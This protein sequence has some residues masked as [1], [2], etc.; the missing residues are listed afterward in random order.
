MS[1]AG[2]ETP[3]RCSP[4]EKVKNNSNVTSSPDQT[5]SLLQPPSVTIRRGHTSTGQHLPPF[6]A[7]ILAPHPGFD[8]VRSVHCV[9][10]WWR[11]H[12]GSCRKSRKAERGVSARTRQRHHMISQH[13]FCFRACR[14]NM[15][16]HARGQASKQ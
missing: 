12:D 13:E 15:N 9:E 10:S 4:F 5:P 8:S 16:T 2:I 3:H 1:S 14:Y 6:R 11:V 7:L